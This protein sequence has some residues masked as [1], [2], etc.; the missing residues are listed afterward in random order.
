MGSPL[1]EMEA[2]GLQ[3]WQ[4]VIAPQGVWAAADDHLRLVMLS[5]L[6]S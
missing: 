6:T 3:C 5:V 2:A 4:D 1:L